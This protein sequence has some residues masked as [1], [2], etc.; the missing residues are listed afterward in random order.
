M[1]GYR[2]F[3]LV[4]LIVLLV[5][6]TSC[7]VTGSNS[8]DA[9]G[10]EPDLGATA[11][12]DSVV[13]LSADRDATGIQALIRGRLPDDCSSIDDISQ[14][15]NGET[16]TMTI[17]I[18]KT[19]EDGCSELPV[20]FEHLIDIDTGDLSEGTY[21]VSVNNV[22]ADFSLK[23]ESDDVDSNAAVGG[24][25]WQD[26]CENLD[27]EASIGEA[28]DSC[29]AARDGS[30]IANSILDSDEIGLGG[31]VVSLGEGICPAKGLA[32]TVTDTRG[33][34]LFGGLR[35]GSY[36]ITVESIRSRNAGILSG[37]HWTYPVIGGEAVQTTVSLSPDQKRFDV[38]FGWEYDQVLENDQGDEG[39][40][41]N[42]EDQDV[43]L[44]D[45]GED[46][47]IIENDDVEMPIARDCT[48]FAAFVAD[49]T[50]P[51][52]T[53][54]TPGE[55]FTKTWRLRNNGTCTWDS[56][57]RLVFVEGDRMGADES[58]D[59]DVPT[60]PS[61]SIDI[62]VNLVAPGDQG[63]Y[64]GEWM[65]QNAENRLFGL[66]RSADAAFWVQIVVN[67]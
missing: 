34:Y 26:T 51:D 56:S 54:F 40:G 48:D 35:S 58:V 65:L 6:I 16:I 3:C 38:D 41:V 46:A 5:A 2:L 22:L 21:T 12:V 17:D 59:L 36:C 24:L 33:I 8:V 67:E 27:E 29:I 18:V 1:T 64:R 13:I 50:V 10:G 32:S 30:Y 31:L 9:L 4:L 44:D 47:D 43:E 42:E 53:R 19:V 57:Y 37:G 62:S 28:P 7:S 63:I 39:T 20:A 52:Y 11:E 23:T 66:G 49:M 55:T 45:A 61:Q 60:S 25:V 14:T 15:R